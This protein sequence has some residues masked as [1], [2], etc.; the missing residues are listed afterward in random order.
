MQAREEGDVNRAALVSSS[1]D[2]DEE[3]VQNNRQQYVKLI[4]GVLLLVGVY[5]AT[6][7]YRHG[8]DVAA[9]ADMAGLRDLASG[10]QVPSPGTVAGIYTY[11]APATAK[12]PL[13]NMLAENHCFDGLRSYTEDVMTPTMKQVDA[14]A[15]SNFYPHALMNTAVLH[16][17]S[18]SLFVPCPGKSTWPNDNNG[19]VF[20]DWGLH[21]END[22][23]PRLQQATVHGKKVGDEEPF[24][25][26]YLFVILAYKSYDS[27]THTMEA[28]VDRMP[29]WKLVARETRVQGSGT[30]YDEDPVMIAQDTETLDCALVFTGTNNID[31]EVATSTTSYSAGYCGF[32]GVHDGYRNELWDITKDLFP[33]LRPKLS[34]CN[35]VSC[36]GHSLGGALCEIFA[37]CANSGRVADPDYQ[38][39]MWAKKTPEEM[40]EITQGAVVYTSDAEKRCEE[41]PCP[42]TR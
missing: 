4:S 13:E 5:C 12:P 39:Q 16:A 30:L 6:L 18:D 11:G 36:V 20:A 14:A 25:S 29:G 35:K 2:E 23:T 32:K 27:T 8:G 1:S 40:P 26:A 28:M 24:A 10:L 22:Y 21:W 3:D 19:D 33:R 7:T 42:K 34:K 38:Q 9:E 37:A 15:I 31:N 41:P 17:G